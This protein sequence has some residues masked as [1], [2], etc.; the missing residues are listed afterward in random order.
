MAKKRGGAVQKERERYADTLSPMDILRQTQQQEN[1]KRKKK[2][3][4]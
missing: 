1:S 2:A 4:K 3:H